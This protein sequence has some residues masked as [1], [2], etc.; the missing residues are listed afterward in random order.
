MPTIHVTDLD[1]NIRQIEANSGDSLMETL[2]DADYDEIA[3]ICGGCCA[4]ATCHVFTD[5]A[6]LEPRSDDETFLLESLD[7]YKPESSRLS[8]QIS[9][10]EDLEG[11]QVTIAP[12]E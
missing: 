5:D 8:C 3:A 2:R 1:G 7:D 4:C 6:R 9:L 12:A 11:L 10:S